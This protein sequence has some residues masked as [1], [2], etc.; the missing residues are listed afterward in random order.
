MTAD[1]NAEQPSLLRRAHTILGVCEAIGEDFGFN[2]LFLRIAFAAG[3]FFSPTGVIAAYL[4]L[5]LIVAFARWVS[6]VPQLPPVVTTEV[7]PVNDPEQLKIA[8]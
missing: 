7:Q 1:Q 8:A 2:P 6:P 5:G 4:G 3:L